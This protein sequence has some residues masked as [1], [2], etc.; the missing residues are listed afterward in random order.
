MVFSH[1]LVVEMVVLSEE[2]KVER[3]KKFLLQRTAFSSSST[4]GGSVVVSEEKTKTATLPTR[5]L[6]SFRLSPTRSAPSNIC[7]TIPIARRR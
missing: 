7:L 6:S 3:T 1:V 5:L 2:R 4:H